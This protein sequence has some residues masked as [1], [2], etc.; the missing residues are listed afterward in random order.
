[1]LTSSS[2][3][4]LVSFPT[5]GASVTRCCHDLFFCS[6]FPFRRQ[7]FTI[8]VIIPD[9]VFMACKICY[10]YTVPVYFTCLLYMY[11]I[12]MLHN[13]RIHHFLGAYMALP[14]TFSFP[15]SCCSGLF[16]RQW[17]FKKFEGEGVCV[18]APH[19]FWSRPGGLTVCCACL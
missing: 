7:T 18:Q 12:D 8:V 19:I 6:I 5:L 11:D 14:P 10:H 16:N 3:F 17:N 2:R 4:S 1:M 15:L 9:R 13:S